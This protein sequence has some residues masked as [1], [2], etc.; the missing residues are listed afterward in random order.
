V[1]L[2]LRMDVSERVNTH[3][4]W[5]RHHSNRWPFIPYRLLRTNAPAPLAAIDLTAYTRTT[6]FH[7]CCT[8]MRA[9]QPTF[10]MPIKCI[11][12]VQV[13]SGNGN[14]TFMLEM[15]RQ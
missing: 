12:I 14:P 9:Q 7:A 13:Y 1:R 11:N 8:L 5:R 15:L 2:S 10:V 6:K 4:T 3:V